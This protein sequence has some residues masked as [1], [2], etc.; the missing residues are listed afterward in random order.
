VDVDRAGLQ[1][2]SRAD[3][4]DLLRTTDLGRVGISWR[5][6]PMILPVHFA[7]DLGRIV[8]ATWDGSILSKATRGTVVAFEAEGPPG[9]DPP[10]WSVLVNGVADHVDAGANVIALDRWGSGHR[11]SVLSITTEQV[12]GRSRLAPCRISGRAQ[13]GTGD[14]PSSSDDRT[15]PDLAVGRP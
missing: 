15:S 12:T 11:Q 5:A 14:P 8:I 7:L 6:M 3:C 4:L 10:S 1:I 2:L 13:I 9:S